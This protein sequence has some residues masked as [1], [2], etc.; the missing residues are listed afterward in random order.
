MFN[1]L[2]VNGTVTSLPVFIQNILNC[3]PKT[4]KAFTGLER[5]GDE[6]LGVARYMYSSR[7]VTVQAS[8][9]GA[10]C[11]MTNTGNSPPI[12]KGAPAAMQRCLITASRTANASGDTEAAALMFGSLYFILIKYQLAVKLAMLEL[13][14]A[15][16]LAS[17]CVTRSLQLFPYT[18]RINFKHLLSY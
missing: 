5:H 16:A 8:R 4:N 13:M 6:W 2:A 7:T 15:S 17:V 11:P 3:V 18:S 12:Q 14:C 1:C 9:F 10:W